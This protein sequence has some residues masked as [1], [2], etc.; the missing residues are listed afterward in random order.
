M[1]C[2]PYK[3]S[4]FVL[5][6]AFSCYLIFVPLCH[7]RPLP[8]TVHCPRS[9]RCRL[10]LQATLPTL[11]TSWPATPLFYT[12]YLFSFPP[13]IYS[14][15][16]VPSTPLFYPVLRASTH[17]CAFLSRHALPWPQRTISLRS[18]LF[19]S[20]SS[21][22]AVAACVRSS[23]LLLEGR[24]LPMGNGP[25]PPAMNM[26]RTPT[27]RQLFPSVLHIAP[28]HHPTLVSL[29]HTSCLS[30][31]HLLAA[32]CAACLLFVPT[33]MWPIALHLHH[34]VLANSACAF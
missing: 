2:V 34:C 16:P 14:S 9:S 21:P 13:T 32:C 15:L 12:L 30:S 27:L 19:T 33:P 11:C 7:R 1:R 24:P 29:S 17:H 28:C 26:R 5:F 3:R 23:I 18:M 20:V 8:P 4:F 25:C 22:L 10:P 6:F 31:A